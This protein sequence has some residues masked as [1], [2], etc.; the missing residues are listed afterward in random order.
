[1]L[2]DF[3]GLPSFLAIEEVFENASTISPENGKEIDNN[4]NEIRTKNKDEYSLKTHR[5]IIPQKNKYL[6][7]VLVIYN[8]IAGKKLDFKKK[9]KDILFDNH[10]LSEFFETVGYLSAFNYV[11]T[12]ANLK[13]FSAI[14]VYGG[15]GTLHEVINGMLMREDEVKKPIGIL[16]GGTGNDTAHGLMINSY[17]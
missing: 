17:E 12:L 6:E 5:I 9:T 2:R 16:P 1:M 4:N 3:H 11:R 13:E 10:I 7:P 15:D 14:I 8:P